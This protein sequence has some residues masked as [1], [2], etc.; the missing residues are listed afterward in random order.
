MKALITAAIVCMATAAMGQER[1]EIPEG[2]WTEDEVLYEV[3][4][5][6]A[7][8]AERMF[9]LTMSDEE[10]HFALFNREEVEGCIRGERT[11]VSTENII[12]L[13]MTEERDYEWREG[14]NPFRAIIAHRKDVDEYIL[15]HPSWWVTEE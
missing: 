5:A 13:F 3:R 6:S 10:A 1:M 12:P 11:L 8:A 2:H 7:D 4:C 9:N 15:L 14:G